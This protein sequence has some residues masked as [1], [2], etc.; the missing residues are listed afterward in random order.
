MNLDK[1][2]IGIR[3]FLRD[4][5]LFEA[6]SGIRDTMPETKIIVADCGEHTEEKDGIYADLVR[7]GHKVI[8]LT[9]D[10]GFGQMSNRIAEALDTPYLLIG[11]DDFS[12]RPPSVRQGI[13]KLVEVLDNTDV[14]IS[15]G[16]VFGPYE[17]N[18]KIEN[19][20]VTEIPV[21]IVPNKNMPI[22]Y[23]ECDLTVNFS[24]IKQHVFDKVRWDDE[25]RIGGG[26]HGA[27]FVDVKR[28]GFKVAYVPGVKIDEQKNVSSPRYQQYRA[29]S[30]DPTRPCFD[31]RG[32]R[33]YVLG[34]GRIDYEAKI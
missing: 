2:S 19:D 34:N 25:T 8:W 32:I 3:T 27:F 30:G 17:F 33:K 11:S 20:V 23:V 31:K 1:V 26:E 5:A 29:R 22:W 13:E 16:R 10:A 12:F 28:A 18:L 24:L 7:E 9:F 15:S 21:Q 4:G 14:D 6:I